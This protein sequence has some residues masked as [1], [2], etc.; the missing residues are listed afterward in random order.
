MNN[1]QIIANVA[2]EAGLYTEDQIKNMVESGREIPLHTLS[3]W[4]YRGMKVKK[5]EHGIECR[6][7]KRKKKGEKIDDTE[8]GTEQDI[9]RSFY[10]ARAY[11]FTESQVEMAE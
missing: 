6:L 1:E 7:W 2:I 11:L 8:E 4:S 5:D 10:L 9:D 3:G